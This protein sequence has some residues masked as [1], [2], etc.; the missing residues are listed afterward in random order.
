MKI[1]PTCSNQLSRRSVTLN[2]ISFLLRSFLE[3]HRNLVTWSGAEKN[4]K[5]RGRRWKMR[6]KGM[7]R[8][9]RKRESKK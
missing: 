4:E 2:F 5:R 1:K 8:K 3:N 6:S 9:R 7:K